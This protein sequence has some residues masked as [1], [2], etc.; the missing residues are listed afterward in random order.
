ME[1]PKI[2]EKSYIVHDNVH[3]I[4]TVLR[5]IKKWK[6]GEDQPDPGK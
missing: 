1:L 4:V 6:V 3:M 5:P 2:G